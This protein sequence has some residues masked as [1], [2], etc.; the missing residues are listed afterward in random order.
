MYAEIFNF[1]FGE[2]ELPYQ[3]SISFYQAKEIF[4]EN[5]T[6]EEFALHVFD[7]GIKVYQ[8]GR[9]HEHL[10]QIFNINEWL[11]SHGKAEIFSGVPE[12]IDVAL[13]TFRFSNRNLKEFKP[14]YRYIHFD[15]AK[16]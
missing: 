13:S 14:D 6:D 8:D 16:G 2:P 4:D 5:A 11:L 12:S 10:R 7:G 9:T 1:V 3:D 15:K